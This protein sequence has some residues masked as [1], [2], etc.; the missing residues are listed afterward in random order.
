MSTYKRLLRPWRC[1]VYEGRNTVLGIGAIRRN[2]VFEDSEVERLRP[3]LTRGRSTPRVLVVIPTYR[4]PDGARRA[5]ESALAQT[6]SDIAV[7]VVDDGAGLP[8]LPADPRLAAVSLRRNT[9][10]LGLVRNVGIRLVDSEFVA[11]LDD[12]NVWTPDHVAAAVAALDADPGLAGV[13]TSVR[14]ERSDGSQIDVLGAPFDAR[15]LRWDPFIDA[16]SI[17]VRRSHDRG[18]SVL[19]RTKSTLPKEDWEYVWRLSRRGRIEHVPAVTVRYAVNPQSYFTHWTDD[20][21]TPG[22]RDA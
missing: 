12:D 18:F 8:V 6:F 5:V 10:T 3:S 16:N 17:V 13:Y 14:R 19:P 2:R 15:R 1:L 11:F 9:A 20:Y 7:I 4:R 21:A 22:R